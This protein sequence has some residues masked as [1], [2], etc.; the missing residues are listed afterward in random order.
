MH[1]TLAM[2]SQNARPRDPEHQCLYYIHTL[3]LH[4]YPTLFLILDMCRAKE[5]MMMPMLLALA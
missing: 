1:K 3:L 5:T 4:V 2:G